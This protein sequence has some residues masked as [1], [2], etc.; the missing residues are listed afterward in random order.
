MKKTI[1]FLIAIITITSSILAQNAQYKTLNGN[2]SP[3]DSCN[4]NQAIEIESLAPMFFTGGYHFALCYRYEG[5]RIRASVINGGKYNAETAGLNNSS[6]NFKRYYKTSPGVFF[7]YNLWKGL[8]LY[9]YLEFHTF[10]IE[11]KTTGIKKDIKSTDF[12]SGIS[13]QYF[14]GK[15]F[16]LQPGIHIY[17]RK[18]NKVDFGNVIYN[19]PNTDISPV[20]RIG[21]RLWESGK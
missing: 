13:Y 14:I 2:N 11:Q 8:E 7:G 4:V 5:F 18:D 17:L 3:Q 21:V 9:T 1:L 6:D 12:G 16:Y 19:I 15:Y 10:E 20:I